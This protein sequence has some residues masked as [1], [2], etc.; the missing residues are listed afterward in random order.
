M[1][2][3]PTA[4]GGRV[5]HLTRVGQTVRRGDPLVRV[6]PP[7][8]QVEEI[9]APL[10]AIVMVQRLS[11]RVAPRYSRM[12]GLKRVVLATA[13]GAVQWIATLGPVGMTTMVALV[14]TGDAVRPHRAGCSGF[15]GER[16]C[17]P[18]EAVK[19]GQPLIEIRGEELV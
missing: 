7:D 14:G 16:F 15:V 5:E 6:H 10:D 12:I 17:R 3:L 11:G 18:G 4:V 2:H 1:I 13:D 19:A 9:C 8:G